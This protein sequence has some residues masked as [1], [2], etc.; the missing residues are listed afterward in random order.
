M[1]QANSGVLSHTMLVSDVDG[2][3]MTAYRISRS[4]D[5]GLGLC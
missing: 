3:C 2:L 4:R 5:T 1:M